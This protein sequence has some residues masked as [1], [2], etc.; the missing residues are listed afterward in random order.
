MRSIPLSCR[1]IKRGLRQVC[2]DGDL[3]G[4]DTSLWLLDFG[5]SDPMKTAL[6]DYRIEEGC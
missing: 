2:E 3:D 6:F 1:L 5:V 4:E